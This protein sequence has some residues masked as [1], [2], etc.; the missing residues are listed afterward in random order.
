MDS[1]RNI[2][3]ELALALNALLGA[4]DALPYKWSSKLIG[5]L[6]ILWV[7]TRAILWLSNRQAVLDAEKERSQVQSEVLVMFSKRA[8]AVK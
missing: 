5:F 1:E 2:L 8:E 3:K 7:P 4:C 6:G